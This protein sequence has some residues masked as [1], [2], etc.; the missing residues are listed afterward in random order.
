MGLGSFEMA[1]R[2]RKASAAFADVKRE[3]NRAVATPAV[4]ERFAKVGL[5]AGGGSP[6]EL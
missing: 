5:E 4:L 3:L 6:A 2:G 1:A